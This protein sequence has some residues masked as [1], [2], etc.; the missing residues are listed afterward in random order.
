MEKMADPLMRTE[1]ERMVGALGQLRP[2][3]ACLPLHEPRPRCDRQ[4]VP[5]PLGTPGGFHA[6]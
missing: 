4:Q 6:D 3:T 2:L 5:V 1:E